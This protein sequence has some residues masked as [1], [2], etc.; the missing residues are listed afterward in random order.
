MGRGLVVVGSFVSVLVRG[1]F[2]VV[3]FRIVE[4]VVGVLEVVI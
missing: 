3:H 4:G 1:V 2:V